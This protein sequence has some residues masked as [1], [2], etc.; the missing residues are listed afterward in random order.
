MSN[1]LFLKSAGIIL[2]KY[3]KYRFFI[4]FAYT[5]IVGITNALLP[6]LSSIWLFFAVSSISSFASGSLDTGGNVLVLDCW[7]HGDS[8]PYLHSI[9]FSFALGSFLAPILAIPFLSESSNITTPTN[10]SEAQELDQMDTVDTKITTLFPLLGVS[11]IIISTGYLVAG[12]TTIKLKSTN[13]QAPEKPSGSDESYG[14]HL[15]ILMVLIALFFFFY[16]G[17]EVSYGL[18]I[19]TFAVECDQNLS[20][21]QGAEITSIFWACFAIMR[22]ASIFTS[23]YLKP[24]YVMILSFVLSLVGAVALMCYG[25]DVLW[26]LQVGSALLGFGMASIYATGLLWLS[27]YVKISNRIGA[28]MSCASGI[29]ADVFPVVIGQYLTEY[30]MILMHV[31]GGTILL[32]SLM[33]IFAMCI[34]KHI[35]DKNS[36]KLANSPEQL[37]LMK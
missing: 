32:C 30:P 1:F 35:D 2:D 23:I 36:D 17:A 24:V 31:T 26:V 22:F 16:V 21:T 27:T 10:A 28:A 25:N 3:L 20:K 6:H 11:I 13:N 18:Y 34:G 33:F 15:W 37:E 19:A 7:K 14:L 9:H 5:F 12:M 4:L 29:G 8:G